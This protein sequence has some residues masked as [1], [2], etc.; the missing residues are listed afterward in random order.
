MAR[1]TY[2]LDTNVVADRI[3][4]VSVIE[5]NLNGVIQLDHDLVICP[6]CIMK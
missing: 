4:R 2:V 6:L 3:N 1:I 5:K